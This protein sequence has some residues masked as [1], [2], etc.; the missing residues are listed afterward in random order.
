MPPD[1]YDNPR[2]GLTAH[3]FQREITAK[4]YEIRVAAVAGNSSLSPSMPPADSGRGST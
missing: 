3:L 1:Q 4:A 2:I